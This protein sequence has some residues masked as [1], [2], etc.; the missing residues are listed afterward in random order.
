[1]NIIEATIQKN[2]S[3]VIQPTGAGKSACYIIPPLYDGKTAIVITPTI[4]L[5]LDQVSKLTKKEIPATLLGS[6]QQQD[7]LGGIRNGDYRLVYV[8][9]ETFFEKT[10][11]EPRQIFRDMSTEGKVSVIAID[12][13]HLV[14]SWK[15]FR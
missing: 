12:E 15:S 6:A 14:A 9:P 10:K 4:S 5:M 2:D 7:V 8:T 11:K 1:M 3:L 13:A